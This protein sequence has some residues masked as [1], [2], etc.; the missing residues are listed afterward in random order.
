MTSNLTLLDGL[1]KKVDWLESR[2][3]VIAQNIQNADTPGYEA[4]DLNEPSFKDLLGSS[5]S[6]L[7]LSAAGAT[8]ISAPGLETTDPKHMTLGGGSAGK[9][10]TK[11][12]NEK[13]PYEISPS[14]NSVVLEEQLL[15]MDKI[16][17]DHRMMTNIYQK[18]I[19][20]LKASTK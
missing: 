7:S 18:N 11:A 1:M 5:A 3:K 15:K 19:D 6:K 14:G 17:A 12:K 2:Q 16:Y 4:Q 20:M 8:N 9:A 10:N 13:D